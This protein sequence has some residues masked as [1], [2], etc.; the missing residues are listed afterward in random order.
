M[1][2]HPNDP[3]AAI[4]LMTVRNYHNDCS[5]PVTKQVMNAL[6]GITMTAI[7]INEF[8]DCCDP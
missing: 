1:T 3:M 4:T 5:L 6:D 8:H 2:N 7:T